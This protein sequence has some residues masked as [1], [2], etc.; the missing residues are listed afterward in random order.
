M[1]Y[2]SGAITGKDQ[3]E[4]AYNLLMG[5]QMAIE[6]AKRGIP[7]YSPH[8]NTARFEIEEALVDVTWQDY[9]DMDYDIIARCSG[10]LMMVNWEE[11]KGAVLERE[12]AIANNIPV[13]YSIEQILDHKPTSIKG[14]YIT[15]D[16]ANAEVRRLI[17]VINKVYNQ[18]GAH[19]N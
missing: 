7:Y 18:L 16:A 9:M 4:W 11:S 8:L 2:I 19:L 3:D 10:I 15:L 6:C 13:F 5:R 1:F 17:G 14:P 12:Y